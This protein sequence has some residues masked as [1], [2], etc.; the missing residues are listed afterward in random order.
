MPYDER[1]EELVS[2]YALGVLDGDELKELEDHIRNNP[3]VYQDLV[4]ENEAAFSQLAYVLQ[5]SS[6]RAGLRYALL[7]D[8]KVATET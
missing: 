6:P 2:A 5:G 3:G 4:N 8:I 1:I 7:A